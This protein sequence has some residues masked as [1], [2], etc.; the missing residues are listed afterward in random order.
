M[1]VVQFL[2]APTQVFYSRFSR[3]PFSASTTAYDFSDSTGTKFCNSSGSSVVEIVPLGGQ[4][5]DLK[6]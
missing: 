6:L 2:E 3:L 4:I 1:L 5:S